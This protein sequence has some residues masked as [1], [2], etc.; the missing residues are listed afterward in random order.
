MKTKMKIM[1]RI[2]KASA[3]ALFGLMTLAPVAQAAPPARGVVVVRGGFYGPGWGWGYPGWYG[4]YGWGPGYGP[5]A[6][7]GTVKIQT[8]VKGNQVFVDGGFAGLTGKLK[9]FALRPGN[10]TIE[11]R[12]SDGRTIYQE[13]VQVIAG[14]TVEI[15]P[16]RPA[17]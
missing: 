10:H 4:Y 9:K 5:Y 15:H 14:R 2:W 7:A 8:K 11:V 17:A 12:D 3:I 16:D 1:S 6:F 13:R